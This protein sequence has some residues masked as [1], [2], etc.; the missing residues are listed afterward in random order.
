V[1][2]ADDSRFDRR[3][4]M[5][6]IFIECLEWSFSCLKWSFGRNSC[7]IWSFFV[8]P[9]KSL[10]KHSIVQVVARFVVGCVMSKMRTI[11]N[12]MSKMRTILNIMSKMRTILN[13]RSK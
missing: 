1:F 2:V 6:L 4:K 8:I 13:I 3:F 5:V 12:I 7:F 11:L 9:F 10:T